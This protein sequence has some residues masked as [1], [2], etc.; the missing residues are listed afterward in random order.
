MIIKTGY[1][2]NFCITPFG[3]TFAQI[4]GVGEFSKIQI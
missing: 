3:D 2:I 4:D 1:F